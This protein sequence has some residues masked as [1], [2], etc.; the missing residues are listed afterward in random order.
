MQTKSIFL[1][2]LVDRQQDTCMFLQLLKYC[3][4][5]AEQ[6]KPLTLQKKR[7]TNLICLKIKV[8]IGIEKLFTLFGTI[9]SNDIIAGNGK[10]W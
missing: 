2:Y 9:R 1:F 6:A 5:T 4:L 8:D 3:S 7:Y 10:V